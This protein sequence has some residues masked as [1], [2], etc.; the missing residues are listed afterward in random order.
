MPGAQGDI[1]G[2]QHGYEPVGRAGMGPRP[3]HQQGGQMHG[4]ARIGVGPAGDEPVLLGAAA[5]GGPQAQQVEAALGE[6]EG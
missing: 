4:V 6:I 3:H 5:E 2:E 1:R